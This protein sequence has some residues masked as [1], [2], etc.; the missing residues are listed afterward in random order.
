MGISHSLPFG[1]HFIQG[2]HPLPL[3]QPYVHQ[4]QGL[5]GGSSLSL[6]EKGAIEL[7]SGY[8]S[9][10]F[11]VMKASGS[12]RLVIDLSLLNL[13]VQ[14]TSFKMETL[15]SVLL[16]VQ[17]GDCMVSLDLKDA[18][19]SDASGKSQVPQIRG[20]RKARF[21]ALGYPR[22]RR[23]SLG[24]WLWFHH[25]FTGLVFVFGVTSMIGLLRRPFRSR[26]S[27][28]WIRFSSFVKLLGLSSI[29]SLSWFLPSGWSIWVYF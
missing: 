29:G 4:G 25:F 24:S 7:V 3:V 15:Q 26:F 9:R 18:Y 13:K 10:L 2:T 8:Y 11:V 19:D 6:L 23:S 16:S 27:L 17:R 21:C 28:L 1:S 20:V 12:W 22:L 14:K 5:G